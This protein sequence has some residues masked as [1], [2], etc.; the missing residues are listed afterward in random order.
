MKALDPRTRLGGTRSRLKKEDEFDA[1]PKR[2]EISL[3]FRDERKL[4]S[5]SRNLLDE[6]F[7]GCLWGTSRY[8][9]S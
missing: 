7:V 5:P 1:T 2:A 3:S 6:V 9:D 8:R 4:M